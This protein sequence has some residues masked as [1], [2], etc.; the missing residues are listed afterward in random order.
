MPEFKKN[1]S[2]AMKKK[3]GFKMKG[4][5]Y[6]GTSPMRNET[7]TNVLNEVEV[8]GGKKGKSLAQRKY[9]EN[10]EIKAEE[11]YDSSR[12]FS[13]TGGVGQYKNLPEKDKATYRASAQRK[14][15]NL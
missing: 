9:E 14:N 13:E 5:T 3:S 11:L 12:A 2:P 7:K 4:Y 15:K 10:L 6:P 8:S 1:T